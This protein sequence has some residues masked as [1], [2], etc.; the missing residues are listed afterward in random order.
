MFGTR[1]R[2]LRE[3]LGLNQVKFGNRIG[4]NKQCVSNWENNNIMPSIDMLVRV[5]KQFSVKNRL[6]ARSG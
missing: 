4:V 6:S 1:I 5:A 2:E 3:S